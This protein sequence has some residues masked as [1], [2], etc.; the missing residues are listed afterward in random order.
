MGP[1]GS[2]PFFMNIL[3]D[4]SPEGVELIIQ[5]HQQVQDIVF[6]YQRHI[7]GKPITDETRKLLRTQAQMHRVLKNLISKGKINSVSVAS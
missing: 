4:I 5:Q 7:S 6:Y 2:G 1:G 3:Q